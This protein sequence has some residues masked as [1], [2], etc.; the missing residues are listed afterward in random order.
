MSVLKATSIAYTMNFMRTTIN[1]GITHRSAHM[2]CL[3]PLAVAHRDGTGQGSPLA[4]LSLKARFTPGLR[5]TRSFPSRPWGE[6]TVVAV[7]GHGPTAPAFPVHSVPPVPRGPR[8]SHR[9]HVTSC[10]SALPVPSMSL[11]RREP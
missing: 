6:G 4:F 5:G 11:S 10:G 2:S 3:W 7:E 1:A 8:V 9:G